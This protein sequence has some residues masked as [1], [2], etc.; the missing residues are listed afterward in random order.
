MPFSLPENQ[1]P[2]L[3]EISQYKKEPIS[4]L[5]VGMGYGNFGKL[6]KDAF[7]DKDIRLTGIEIWEPYKNEQWSYYDETIL[8]DIS[9]LNFKLKSYDFI[10]AIDVIEHF[11]KQKGIRII[12]ELKRKAREGLLVSVP[13]IDMP[14]GSYEGNPYEEHKH[15]WKKDE[16]LRLGAT[17]IFEGQ[18]LGVFKFDK[19]KKNKSNTNILWVSTS[20]FNPGSFSFQSTPVY[21]GLIEK[22]YNV[23]FYG[24]ELTEEQIFEGRKILPHIPGLEVEQCLKKYVSDYNIDLII[25]LDHIERLFEITEEKM[26]VPVYHWFQLCADIR[27][28]TPIMPYKNFDDRLIPM[29]R[30]A[31]NFLKREKIRSLKIIPHLVDP[32]DY[33]PL[34]NK[35]SLKRMTGLQNM[36][37]VGFVADNRR[38]KQVPL[39]LEG[40]KTFSQNKS[41]V[42]LILRTNI[43][44]RGPVYDLNDLIKRYGLFDKV[45]LDS[46]YRDSKYMNKIY[47]LIDLLVMPSSMEGFGIPIIEAMAAGCP[48]LVNDAAAM[49]EK[50]DRSCVIKSKKVM[51]GHFIEDHMIPDS[52]AE[53]LDFFYK[54][55]EKLHD[56]CKKN[57]TKVVKDYSKEKVISDWDDT[58]KKVIANLN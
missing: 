5:D 14:Q 35:S 41:D 13:I 44:D 38:E 31:H 10:L 55:R 42:R 45:I 1:E 51:C 46:D 36:F 37:L 22:G 39:L 2:I 8:D 4:I 28:K 3:R 43:K 27:D 54:H 26:G 7:P 40:F 9:N 58:I 50:V 21:K 57:L 30:F 56:Q 16:M 23:Y 6:I 52:L 48:V 53:R 19:T 32:T 17:Q 12:N 11:E 47:N 29:S 20:P 25:F 49:P 34:N 18:N 24:W 33:M 15:Q